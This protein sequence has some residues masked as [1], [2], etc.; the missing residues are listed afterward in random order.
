V[1]Y[2]ADNRFEFVGDKVNWTAPAFMVCGDTLDGVLS[3]IRSSRNAGSPRGWGAIQFDDPQYSTDVN[4]RPGFS[5]TL[6]WNKADDAFF[7]GGA[8]RAPEHTC[9]DKDYRNCPAIGPP[10]E[11]YAAL[12][13]KRSWSNGTLVFR[14]DLRSEASLA[15][16][17]QTDNAVWRDGRHADWR[18]S[19]SRN[20]ERRQGLDCGR[21]ARLQRRRSRQL[22][23][24]SADYV[25]PAP[26]GVGDHQRRA[27]QSRSL[28]VSGAG[29]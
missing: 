17:S 12:G 2:Q 9:G 4:L 21:A 6:D 23:L 20:L 26:G 19:E 24:S 18:R 14:P 22:S 3:G 25:L 27:A 5:L 15:G 11:P 28:A 7:F 16:F 8:N 29:Q 1:C 10:L 13:Q